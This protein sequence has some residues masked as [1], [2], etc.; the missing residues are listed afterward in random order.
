MS[1]RKIWE[2]N[3]G[4]RSKLFDTPEELW[5]EACKYFQ[6]CVDNPVMESQ[7]VKYKDYHKIVSL[8]HLRPFT[9]KGLAIF[10]G[11][12]GSYLKNFHNNNKDADKFMPTITRIKD[13][14]FDQKFS[15]AMT[16]LF[17]PML[18]A[19]DL[20]ISDR[21]EITAKVQVGEIESMSQEE[22]LAEIERLDK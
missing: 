22:L 14:I 11:C 5:E 16:G 13:I 6:W 7:I 2:K 20:G 15:G 19:R 3:P 21:Q 18:V 17:N 4:G 1:D 8:P 9:L 12:S 10:M